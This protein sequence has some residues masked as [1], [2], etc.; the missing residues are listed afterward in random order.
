MNRVCLYHITFKVDVKFFP[1]EDLR[2][3][4]EISFFPIFIIV[5][6]KYWLLLVGEYIRGKVLDSE[7]KGMES[8]VIKTRENHSSP[9]LNGMH[10]SQISVKLLK[11]LLLFR[12]YG[13]LL[14][15]SVKMKQGSVFPERK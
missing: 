11:P 3:T 1:F 4:F 7:N 9:S 2:K 6:S 12:T 5:M 15:Y 8:Q 13:S 14:Y 10:F